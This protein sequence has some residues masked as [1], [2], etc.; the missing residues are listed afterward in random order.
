VNGALPYRLTCERSPSVEWIRGDGG[1]FVEPFF[2]DTVA[3]LRRNNPANRRADRLRAP[4]SAL[5]DGPLGLPV[6]GIIFH[7]SRCGSTLVSQMLAA[8]PRN[9]VLSEPQLIDD[10]LRLARSDATLSDEEQISLLRGAMNALSQRPAGGAE[11]CFLKTDCWH[12][13]SLPLIQRA[14]PRV[15]LLFVYREPVQVLVSLMR[16]PSLTL[17]RGTVTPTQLDLTEAERDR[18]T[19]EEH[20]AAI[21]AAFFR[22][23]RHHRAALTPIAYERLPAALLDAIPHAIGG[24]TER[25]QLLFAATRNAKDPTQP[26]DPDSARKGAEATGAVLAAAAKWTAPAYADWLRCV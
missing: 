6:G 22:T 12:I 4:L 1:R 3:R 9:L 15:P 11:R 5:R 23:A 26:F 16:R 24:N 18:L 19:P 25:A 8:S 21:L 7:V 2:E 20:A 17:V 14:F 13:F 10:L